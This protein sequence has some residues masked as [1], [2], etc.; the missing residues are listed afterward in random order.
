LPYQLPQSG[1]LTWASPQEREAATRWSRLVLAFIKEAASEQLKQLPVVGPLVAGG[2]EVVQ[3]L[4]DEDVNRE[5]AAVLERLATGQQDTA[6]G[7]EQLQHD[8]AVL[9]ALSVASFNLQ[10][11][12]LEWLTTRPDRAD[13]TVTPAALNG[14]AMQAALVAYSRR[15]ALDW[16]YADHRG[17]PGEAA[18]AHVA[19]LPLDEVYVN[20]VLLAEAASIEVGEREQ[21]LLLLLPDRDRLSAEEYAR[22]VEEYA[23]LTGRRWRPGQDAAQAAVVV[24]GT[25]LG[26]VR[27]AVVLGGPGVGKSALTRYLART[28][29]LGVE[30]VRQ[31]LGWQEAPTPVL[32]P[33]AAYADART[34]RPGL[35]LQS[36]FAALLLVVGAS[37]GGLM[38]SSPDRP[39]Q[40]ERRIDRWA[41]DQVGEQAAQL[42]DGERDQDA[43]GGHH[44]CPPSPVVGSVTWAR[45][46]ARNASAVM[47][48]VMCRYQARYWRT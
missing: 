30:A 12:L 25:A 45:V 8:L 32:V 17:I 14:F 26:P 24:V 4:S 36:Q 21:E 16:Q 18:A 7:V 3:R 39:A 44:D 31:R 9:T 22:C 46:T 38:A 42:G 34:Q 11:Q 5:A 48:R 33:L 40:R 28:C 35:V 13:A 20:P 43:Q 1:T 6:V 15:V 2:L 47:A 29:G 37:S 19:S 41:P 10:G 27:H 23:A